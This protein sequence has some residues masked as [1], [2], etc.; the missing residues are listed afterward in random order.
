MV[1]EPSEK[2]IPVAFVVP[3]SVMNAD[4]VVAPAGAAV[5]HP[6]TFKVGG[7]VIVGVTG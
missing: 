6:E 1:T 7:Q 2:D 5:L 3:P 4:G